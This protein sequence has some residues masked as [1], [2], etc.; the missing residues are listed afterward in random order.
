[1]ILLQK[2]FLEQFKE[3]E[4]ELGLL[5]SSPKDSWLLAI[6]AV[7]FLVCIGLIHYL[8]RSEFTLSLTYL[9]PVGFASWYIGTRYGL[10]LSV[11]SVAVWIFVEIASNQPYSPIRTY[12]PYAVARL[13]FCV[14]VTLLLGR[15][16]TALRAEQALSRVD[17]LTGAVNWRSFYESASM[18]IERCNR[19][20]CSFTIAY[21]DI[22]NFKNLNDRFGH[23]TGDSVLQAIANTVRTNIRKVDVVARLG[24]DEFVILFPE[25]AGKAASTAIKKIKNALEQNKYLKK[26]SVTFSIGILTCKEC[27]TS[28]D[29]TITLADSLMYSAKK[30]GKNG[31]AQSIYTG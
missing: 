5:N 13:S 29:S 4:R 20:G 9:I 6:A 23:T 1:L 30:R 27:P 11:L 19:Y 25:T 3:W 26:L 7:A 16:K 14:G 21:I 28:V 24:G 17:Y 10:F 22:D 2:Q 12:C 18:E 8:L 31:I 15:F